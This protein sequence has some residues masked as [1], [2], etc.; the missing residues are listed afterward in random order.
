[1][2]SKWLRQ[3]WSH[4]LEDN[5][6]Y[7]VPR[8]AIYA[9][10]IEAYVNKILIAKGAQPFPAGTCRVFGFLDDSNVT[11]CRPGSGPAGA[12]PVAPRWDPLIQEAFYDG[13]LRAHGIKHET[14]HG[15][16]GMMILIW[17]PASLAQRSV[18]TSRK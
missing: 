16:D 10:K 17:G 8:F 6:A 13:W 7:F 15:P 2:D 1:M 14:L 12:G 3:R 5:L 9:S 11:T 18:D 4:K